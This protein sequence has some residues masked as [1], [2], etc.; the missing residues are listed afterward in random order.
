M[1]AII[2]TV[3]MCLLWAADLFN[4]TGLGMAYHT[5]ELA[6]GVTIVI[7]IVFLASQALYEGD[8]LVKP[9]YFY[10]IVPLAVLIL[11]TAFVR[12]AGMKA[13]QIFWPFMLV[14]ILSKTRPSMP[15]IRMTA[16]AFAAMGLIVLLVF[17]YTDFFKG[18]NYNKI[19]MLGMAS[20][21]GFTIPFFGMREWRS[22]VVMPVIGTAYVILIWPTDSRSCCLM[23][24][25]QLLLILRI[26]PIK[27]VFEKKIGRILLLLVPLFVAVFVVLVSAFGDISGLTQWS[28]ETFNK[29]LFNGR[30][31]IW[32][33]GLRIWW[34][35]MLFGNAGMNT[36]HWHNSAISCLVSFGA[37]GYFLWVRMFH[38][39]TSE[40]EQYLD[41][42]CVMGAMTAFVVYY[43]QQSVE[44]GLF[45]VQPTIMPYVLLGMMLGRV[46]YLKQEKKYA[47]G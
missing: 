46:N 8:L 28:Y 22:F 9:E 32:K 29:P 17:N 27:H 2:Y 1:R 19:G 13:L 10:T 4:E 33:D 26:V 30:D 11:A 24:V 25:I 39:L 40:G 3:F 18:W 23:I 34:Q 42:I 43:C 31:W 47:Q 14:Y 16:M 5:T 15:A 41:D 7:A 35:H 36:G 37:L 20:F 6:I 21:L 45:A 44:L 12:G 38:L